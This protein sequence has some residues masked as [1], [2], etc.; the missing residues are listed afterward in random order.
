MGRP[1]EYTKDS[2]PLERLPQA[3][4][5]G[6]PDRPVHQSWAEGKILPPPVSRVVLGRISP[7]DRS[8]ESSGSALAAGDG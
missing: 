2:I 1:A 8:F 7:P 4:C 6:K 3:P 5:P